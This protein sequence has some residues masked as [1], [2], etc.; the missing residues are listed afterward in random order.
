MAVH[1]R[2]HMVHQDSDRKDALLEQQEHQLRTQQQVIDRQAKQLF[3]QQLGLA[4][5][6]RIIEN[7]R[8][9]S[10][11]HEVNSTASATS[12]PGTHGATCIADTQTINVYDSLAHSDFVAYTQTF[13]FYGKILSNVATCEKADVVVQDDVE[14]RVEGGNDMRLR[15]P[16][17]ATRC[18]DDA[19]DGGCCRR[20]NCL[21][22][23]GDQE[24]TYP[25]IV[26]RLE[27]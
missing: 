22:L 4:T 16:L 7:F 3:Q 2:T 1:G 8:S 6:D 23:D 20:D 27:R 25:E 14:D 24:E 18:A 17:Y 10:E 12:E 15:P 5:K 21:Y 9:H 26:K 13:N 19:K 11:Q